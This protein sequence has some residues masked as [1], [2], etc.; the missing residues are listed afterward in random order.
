MCVFTNGQSLLLWL[1]GFKAFNNL[2]FIFILTKQWLPLQY[3]YRVELLPVFGVLLH[4]VNVIIKIAVCKLVDLASNTY[5][6]A[7]DKNTQ[8]RLPR[9]RLAFL[10]RGQ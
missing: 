6:S 5:A 2:L 8:Q 7:V 4:A 1:Q 10:M 3:G 9:D